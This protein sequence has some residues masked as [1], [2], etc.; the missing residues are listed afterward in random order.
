MLS[1]NVRMTVI[2]FPPRQTPYFANAKAVIDFA[3]TMDNVGILTEQQRLELI[4]LVMESD[5]GAS[6]DA[7]RALANLMGQND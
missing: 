1:S 2:P 7:M 4:K 6:P 3:R 5:D